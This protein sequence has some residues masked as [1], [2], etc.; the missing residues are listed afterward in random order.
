ML[1]LDPELT[2]SCGQESLSK[3]QRLIDEVLAQ[4]YE[5][6]LACGEFGHCLVWINS[7][8][9]YGELFSCSLC[10]TVTFTFIFLCKIASNLSEME[11]KVDLTSS[12]SDRI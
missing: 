8:T 2:I 4:S 11:L 3:K 7:F 1:D 12:G 5:I 6:A 10:S 9:L